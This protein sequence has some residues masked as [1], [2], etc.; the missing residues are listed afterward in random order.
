MSE[1]GMHWEAGAEATKT[2][3]CTNGCL[4][5]ARYSPM[6]SAG[7]IT[8]L[9]GRRASLLLLLLPLLARGSDWPQY[10]GANHDGIT[11]DRLLKVWSG[12][13]TNPVWRVPITNGL[14]SLT[15]AGGRVFTQ[16]WRPTNGLAKEFCLALNSTNG[17]ELWA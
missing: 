8:N 13:V 16:M 10:R 12:S 15:V 1:A 17:T 2:E 4:R 9:L 3:A 7:S 5:D 11:S 14:S 6:T